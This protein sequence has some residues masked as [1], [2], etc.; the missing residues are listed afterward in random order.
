VNTL[1]PQQLA[2][3]KT[4]DA[5]LLVLAG[6]GSGKTSVITEKIAWLIRQGMPAKQIAAVTF[7]NKAARE[8]KARVGKLLKG[9]QTRGLR[10]STFHSLGLDIIRRESKILGFQGGLSILDE[11]DKLT[12]LKELI[13][14][15]SVTFDPDLIDRYSWQ[16]GNWKNGC[17][18]PKQAASIPAND[19][20]EQSLA[21]AA[22]LY[23]EYSRQLKAYNAVDFDDLIFLPVLL[24]SEHPDVLERWQN[25]IRYLLVDEYQDTNQTQYRLIKQIVGKLG[26]LTVV[27]DDD[28]S[29]YA[30]RG[31]QP[32]NLSLLQKDFPR[33]KVVKLEQNYRSTRRI[34]RVANHLIANNPHPFEKKLW[35]D[36]GEGDQL[37][38]VPCKNDIHE[39]QQIA[40]EIIHHKFKTGSQY[41]DYAILYRSNHLSR[42]LEKALRENNIPYHLSGGT[43]FFGYTEIKDLLAYFRLLINPDD[44]SAFIRIVNTPKREIG[45]A[46]LEKLGSY[47]NNRKISLFDACFELGLK[48]RLS[49]NVVIKL[50]HF[51][52]MITDV[53]DRLKRGDTLAVLEEFLATIHYESWVKENSPNDKAS[54]RRIANV[55]ELMDWIKRLLEEEKGEDAFE[56]CLSKILLLDILEQNEDETVTDNVRLM[57]LH[58]AKGLEF[59]NVYLMGIEENI[60]PHQNSIE[61]DQVEEERRLA[62]VGITRAQRNLTITYCR[63]RKRYGELE[64]CEA[65]RFLE[66]LPQ[67]DLDWRNKRV[68]DPEA[69][70]ERSKASIAQ[71]KSMLS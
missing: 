21:Y 19:D 7:T 66:E 47:A 11:Q 28:Q 38:I 53:A 70:K 49:E 10:V 34:L 67:E 2:A 29:I 50:C 57:T 33:L 59:S 64:L 40:S 12:I 51:C 37:Q 31:A 15:A 23:E 9:D 62:Y 41:H 13:S 61:S 58:A 63:Q 18:T 65:S 27:G 46:T 55:S 48:E 17:I 25:K 22:T 4:T 68:K 60:L 26:K 6:A 32:E 45:P 71:L 3:V 5:P 54:A 16:I 44:G 20:N 30:W 69:Q 42:P 24:F 35:S 14:H 43:S 1:N 39:A 56:K 36:L 8:M 52:E